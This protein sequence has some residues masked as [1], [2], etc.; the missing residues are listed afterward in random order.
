ML[1]QARQR[2][3]LYLCLSVARERVEGWFTVPPPAI[4]PPRVCRNYAFALCFFCTFLMLYR[5]S[6]TMQCFFKDLTTFSTKIHTAAVLQER[7]RVSTSFGPSRKLATNHTQKRGVL[8]NRGIAYSVTRIDINKT[9]FEPAQGKPGTGKALCEEPWP[10]FFRHHQANNTMML[11]HLEKQA[12][13]LQQEN[14]KFRRDLGA[15]ERQLDR[16]IAELNAENG[17]LYVGSC[18]LSLL[19]DV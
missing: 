15:R 1:L 13:K 5:F 12:Q 3:I 4:T 10:S 7:Y 18:L 11:Q 17:N 16:Q 14:D 6:F 2:N 19:L 8:Q 9:S